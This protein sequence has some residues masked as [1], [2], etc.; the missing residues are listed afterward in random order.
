MVTG[1]GRREAPGP[2]LCS[3]QIRELPAAQAQVAGGVARAWPGAWLG[4]SC[5][6]VLITTTLL[7]TL[8]RPS[9]VP[10]VP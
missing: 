6:F 5:L 1:L 3:V 2:V 4:S 10:F 8:L 7:F 9:A